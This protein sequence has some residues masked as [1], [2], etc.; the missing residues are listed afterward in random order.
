MPIPRAFR[1][2]AIRD[3]RVLASALAISVF[4]HGLW[5][6]AMV[7]QVKALGGGPVELSVVA[8]ATSVGILLFVLLGGIVADRVPGRRVLILVETATL[9]T[10]ATVATLAL[11]GWLRLFPTR[12][13]SLRTESRARCGRCCSRRRARPPRVRWWQPSAPA[14]RSRSWRPAI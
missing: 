13:S 8:T 3:Y 2:F 11:G 1:P 10:V 12:C 7:Y 6:V 4:G 9:L 14:M 5:A